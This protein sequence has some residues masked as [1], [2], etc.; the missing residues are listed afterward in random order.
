MKINKKIFLIHIDMI[1][2]GSNYFGLKVLVLAELKFI[3]YF[4]KK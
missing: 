2:Q 1:Y 3:N 4:D